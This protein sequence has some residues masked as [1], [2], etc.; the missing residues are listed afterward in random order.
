[1]LRVALFV[2]VAESVGEFSRFLVADSVDKYCEFLVAESV[3]KYCEVS[4]SVGG[5]PLVA[6]TMIARLVVSA[7]IPNDP[8]GDAVVVGFAEVS[9]DVIVVDGSG[10]VTDPPCS[11]SSNPTA[12]E[13][14]VSLD[15]AV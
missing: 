12:P 4:L 6:W 9:E 5:V 14:N 11:C 10:R 3:D 8:L 15:I 13:T 1:M 2:L 7:V